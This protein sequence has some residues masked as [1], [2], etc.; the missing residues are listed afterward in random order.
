MINDTHQHQW[1]GCNQ[2]HYVTGT[3]ADV[4]GQVAHTIVK[5]RTAADSTSALTIPITL[6]SNDGPAKGSYLVSIDIY[7]EILTAV[8][9]AITPV[10]YLAVIPADTA[11]FAAP[12][13]QAFTYDTNHNTAGNRVAVDQH[14]M[15]LTITTPIWIEDDGLVLIELTVDDSATGVFDFYGARANF[16]TRL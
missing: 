5:K 3:W 15:T 8:L 11:A 7:Y 4:A 2:C 16:T 6:P 9:D 14:T 10:I 1:I 12:T 13:T